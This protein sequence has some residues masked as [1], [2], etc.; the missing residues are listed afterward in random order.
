MYYT[1]MRLLRLED[2]SQFSYSLVLTD[3]A[4]CVKKLE[5]DFGGPV[6][7]KGIW[8]TPDIIEPSRIIYFSKDKIT[9]IRDSGMVK[10]FCQSL[11]S[12]TVQN[13]RLFFLTTLISICFGGSGVV[14]WQG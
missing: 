8:P 10:M 3:K 7:L 14:P 9:E 4:S 11:E 2:I 13:V 6:E 1:L 5:L 12:T